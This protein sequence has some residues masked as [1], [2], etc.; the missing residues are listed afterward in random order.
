[1]TE[2]AGHNNR[3][4]RRE[5]MHGLDSRHHNAKAAQAQ[6]FKEEELGLCNDASMLP[7]QAQHVRESKERLRS[8][9]REIGREL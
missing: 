5:R 2:F 7:Q 1:M 4:D 6:G 9:H 8:R 3:C